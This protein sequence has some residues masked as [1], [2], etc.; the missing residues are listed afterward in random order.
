M[1]VL[2]DLDASVASHE[3]R[4][5]TKKRMTSLEVTR[6]D[7]KKLSLDIKVCTTSVNNDA[8]LFFVC[9]IDDDNEKRIYSMIY[10]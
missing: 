4:D 8:C 7:V 3:R 1:E 6:M 10:G 2:N 5:S 9:A